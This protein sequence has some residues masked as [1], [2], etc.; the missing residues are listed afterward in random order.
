MSGNAVHALIQILHLRFLSLKISFIF[1]P[2]VHIFNYLIQIGN[3]LCIDSSQKEKKKFETHR[4]R[5]LR[6]QRACHT[7]L[8]T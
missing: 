3:I 4:E 8:I 1:N 2:V 7:V 5:Q 6:G